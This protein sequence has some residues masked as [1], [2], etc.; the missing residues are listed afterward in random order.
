MVDR[1]VITIDTHQSRSGR[2]RVANFDKNLARMREIIGEA[3]KGYPQLVV[4]DAGL[5]RR[6]ATRGVSVFLRCRLD[7]G[8]GSGWRT[9]LCLLLWPLHPQAQYVLHIDGDIMF[10]GGSTTWIRMRSPAWR[11]A[12]TCS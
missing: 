12:R 3:A 8:Q 2:Y 9:V 11:L 1:F 5:L 4:A 10:G 7:T 6:D